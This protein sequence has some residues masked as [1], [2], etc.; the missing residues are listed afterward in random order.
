MNKEHS[1][2]EDVRHGTK[3]QPMTVMRFAAGPK[4]YYP[5]GFLCRD[6]GIAELR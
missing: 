4:T 2:E 3:E 1:L 5:D 6:T